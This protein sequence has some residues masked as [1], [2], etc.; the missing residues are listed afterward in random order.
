[1]VEQLRLGIRKCSYILFR[2]FNMD[3]ISLIRTAICV[4][5]SGFLP[6]ISVRQINGDFNHFR[7]R[8][9]NQITDFLF[10]IEINCFE[11]IFLSDFV[12]LK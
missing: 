11:M 4:F 3:L 2:V 1:M 12:I 6:V 10:K 8:Q 9:K 5:V 7:V